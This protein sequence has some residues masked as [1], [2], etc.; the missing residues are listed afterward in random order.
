MTTGTRSTPTRSTA[1]CWRRHLPYIFLSAGVTA[2]LFCKTLEF[3]HVSHSTFNGVLCGRATWADG[4]ETYC[5]EGEDGCVK[6][7]Q[8]Q[9]KRN[10]EELNEVLKKTATPI[11]F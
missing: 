5:R 1:P 10:V 11:E 8:T 4:V 6:W 2:E 3:A 9:G 7:L